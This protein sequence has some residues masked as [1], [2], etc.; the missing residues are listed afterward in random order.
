MIGDAQGKEIAVL[1]RAFAV[2]AYLAALIGLAALAAYVLGSGL[3]IWPR[4]DPT[5][6]AWPWLIDL[7]WLAVFALQHS[8][9]ARRGF[10]DCLPPQLERSIYVA[11]SGVLTLVQPFIWQPLPGPLL[12]DGPVWIAA[13]SLTA[14]LA[15]SV[16]CAGYDLLTFMGLRQAG[17]GA[18]AVND[19]LRITGAYRWVRHPLMLGTLVFLWAQPAMRPELA[20]LN[21]GVTLYVL[22]AIRLEER[23]L[24]RTFGKAY[25]EY[26][27]RVPALIPWRGPLA[28]S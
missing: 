9:M 23:E 21:G 8:G 28:G 17:I 7:G 1:V 5:D 20:L 14:A 15:V 6:S 27:R 4:G 24:L 12:W 2:A 10:K 22:V 25:D 3:Q 16:C 19:T 26:R 18:P 11:A 13:I